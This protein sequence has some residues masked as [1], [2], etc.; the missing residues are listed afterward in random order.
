MQT[1]GVTD[2]TETASGAAKV[3]GNAQGVETAS[4]EAKTRLH[5]CSLEH[6]EESRDAINV[7]SDDSPNALNTAPFT[8][9]WQDVPLLM[10]TPGCCPFL[11]AIEWGRKCGTLEANLGVSAQSQRWSLPMS[12]ELGLCAVQISGE[13]G[14]DM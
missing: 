4:E 14:L 3:D 7:G 10:Q 5:S 13:S 1:Y 6:R 9:Q 8:Y 11:R 12:A 2:A